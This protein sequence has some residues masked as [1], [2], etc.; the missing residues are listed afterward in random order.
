MREKQR[1][2]LVNWIFLITVL[3]YIGARMA[4]S[5]WLERMDNLVL[6]MGVSQILLAVPTLG[7]LSLN[8]ESIRESIRFKKLKISRI[9]LL[10]VLGELLLPLVV[11]IN[12]L[13]MLFTKN[14]MADGMRGLADMPLVAGLLMSAVLPAF[15]EETIYRGVFYNEYRKTGLWRGILLSSL[16]FALMH[17]NLNQFCYA[18]VMALIFGVVLEVTDSILSVMILH[19]WINGNSVINIHLQR[20]AEQIFGME[21]A[22]TV[23]E[24]APLVEVSQLGAAAMVPTVLAVLVI[25]WLAKLEDRTHIWGELFPRRVDRSTEPKPRLL[26][27]PLLAGILICLGYIVLY[28]INLHGVQ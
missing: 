18:F 9:L 1:Y 11:F 17:L 20:V 2:E 24:V 28:E 27:S 25:C 22:E 10:M 6:Q 15:L 23:S 19:F 3:F 14:V 7:W 12:S 16:L 21:V 13:T 5:G 8:G 26:T 4:L